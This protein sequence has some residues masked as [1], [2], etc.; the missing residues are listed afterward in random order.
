[1][2]SQVVEDTDLYTIEWD[3]GLDCFVFT[4]NDFSSG[5]RFKRGANAGL[6]EFK[7]RD[8]SKV[9]VDASAVEAH[10][11]SD[12]QW[13]QEHWTP[14]MIDAGADAIV[15][16]TAESVISQMDAEEIVE[17]M[18]HLPYESY[19]TSSMEDARDWIASR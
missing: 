7:R 9:I 1:M 5:D 6:E 13:I 16:I 14:S 2:P 15:T 12:Q 8:C 19:M 18:A 10:D 3:E 17:G 4:W 11:E